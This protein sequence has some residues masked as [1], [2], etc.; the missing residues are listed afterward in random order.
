MN[1]KQW[2]KL[3]ILRRV[4]FENGRP[5]DCHG[6]RFKG[7]QPFGED[8]KYWVDKISWQGWDYLGKGVYLKPNGIRVDLSNPYYME[9]L[10]K[11]FTKFAKL[12]S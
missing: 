2:F 1:I 9:G 12:E 7:T 4:V 5:I 6:L 11:T 10:N 8:T 3:R